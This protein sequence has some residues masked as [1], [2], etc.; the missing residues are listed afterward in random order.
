MKWA[1]LAAVIFGVWLVYVAWHDQ[2]E[3]YYARPLGGLLAI[4]GAFL[5]ILAVRNDIIAA[6]ERRDPPSGDT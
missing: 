1:G 4:V 3:G 6:I 5:V 2:V